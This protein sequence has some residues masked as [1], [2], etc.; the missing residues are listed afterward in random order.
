MDKRKFY[1]DLCEEEARLLAEI[2]ALKEI[3]EPIQVLK[4]KYAIDAVQTK[5][6]YTPRAVGFSREVKG[7]N[8]SNTKRPYKPRNGKVTTRVM[9]ALELVK[10]GTAVKV[11]ETLFELYPDDFTLEQAKTAAKVSLS[12]LNS[13]GKVHGS[14]VQGTNSF[15]YTF[16]TEEDMALL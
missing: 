16:L 6:A 11:G 13:E 12:R 5:D 8:N 10:S 14:K 7:I 15:T 2:E 4:L 1:N 9:E 3:L